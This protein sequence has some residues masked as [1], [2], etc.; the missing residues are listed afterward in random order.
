MNIGRNDQCPCGSGKKY[1][2]CCMNK[3]VSLNTVIGPEL[4]QLQE[5]L[6]DYIGKNDPD[7]IYQ[8]LA[9]KTT[10]SQIENTEVERFVSFLLVI[11][12]TFHQPHSTSTL[13]EQ[14][15]EEKRKSNKVRPSTMVQLEKWKDTPPSFVT[16]TKII[17]HEWIEVEDFATK[18]IK[19]V[20]VLFEESE[21]KEGLMLFGFLL[22]YGNYYSYMRFAL[23]LLPEEASS[24]LG[25]LTAMFKNSGMENFTEFLTVE[26]PSI[27]N[28]L[29]SQPLAAEEVNV[30]GFVWESP[31]Y[32]EVVELFSRN[33]KSLEGIS[34][35]LES[36]GTMIWNLYCQRTKPSIRKAAVY[37]AGLQYFLEMNI[38]GMS[39]HTQKDLAEDYG[40]S[41][42]SLS[43]AFRQME[44]E[45]EEEI[46]GMNAM[47]EKSSKVLVES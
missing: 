18:E 26:Y 47:L 27:I 7:T 19:K 37:A 20:R 22:P 46:E 10:L 14:F 40:V 39:F 43:K 2:K 1:K 44:A 4:D 23:D 29:I 45:L 38:P 28:L 36:A 17:D 21:M 15:I 13:A 8:K 34:D 41:A 33:I 24:L 32:Q 9:D 5:Q 30:E 31:V 12:F 16:I 3:V 11:W 25:T 42:A 6:F 35:A